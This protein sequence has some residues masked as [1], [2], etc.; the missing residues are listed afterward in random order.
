MRLAV[1]AEAILSIFSGVNNALEDILRPSILGLTTL[2]MDDYQSKVLSEGSGFGKD[3]LNRVFSDASKYRIVT[4]DEMKHYDL[5]GATDLDDSYL[6]AAYLNGHRLIR[7]CVTSDFL[8]HAKK[9]GVNVVDS[10]WSIELG[11]MPGHSLVFSLLLSSSTNYNHSV[12]RGFF[13]KERKIVIYDRYLKDSS[14][15]FFEN[16]LRAAHDDVELVVISK[17]DQ[18]GASLLSMVE[19]ER[20]LRK[21]KPKANISC[22]YPDDKSQADKHDRHVHLG[23]RLQLSFSSGTDC[24]GTHPDWNNSECEISVHYLT[25]ASPVRSYAV[26]KD[27]MNTRGQSV[28]VHA[29]I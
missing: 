7:E 13:S 6:G 28:R 27:K 4:D 16:V 5:D 29:K 9:Y 17:F 18:G 15:R 19:V 20:V 23:A 2:I 14:L 25:S 10:S 26:F 12:L 22:Y 1:D 11:S 21:V 3:W 8:E 24:F